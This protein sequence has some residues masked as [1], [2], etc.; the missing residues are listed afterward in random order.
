MLARRAGS[1]GWRLRHG[2]RTSRASLRPG[3]AA[4]DRTRADEPRRPASEWMPASEVDPGGFE[5]PTFSLR[6]R[7]ATNC[8]MGPSENEPIIPARVVRTERERRVSR[9]ARRRRSTAS[10]SSNAG[11]RVVD[12]AHARVGAHGLRDPA[13]G[14]RGLGRRRRGGRR[15]RD[16]RHLGL[17]LLDATR[18]LRVRRDALQLGGRLDRRHRHR[19]DRAA[20]EVQGRRQRLRRPAVARRPRA[21]RARSAR[22]A[23]DVGHRDRRGRRPPA[24][25][26]GRGATSPREARRPTADGAAAGDEQARRRT[27]RPRARRRP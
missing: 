17:E 10:R 19:G 27:P 24:R 7:R 13:I 12:D 16:R 3:R 20:R 25:A 9:P 4:G 11:L 14:C 26:R 21:R 2:S 6:T 15:G 22:T 18:D 23:S 5:P 8:A 1:T